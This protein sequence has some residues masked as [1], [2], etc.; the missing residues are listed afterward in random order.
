MRH[1]KPHSESSSKSPITSPSNGRA[2]YLSLHFSLTFAPN[3]DEFVVGCV[4]W[5][6]IVSPVTRHK[7]IPEGSTAASM[8][9]TVTVATMTIFTTIE[10]FIWLKAFAPF[11][12][13]SSL[14]QSKIP[15]LVAI[16]SLINLPMFGPTAKRL[17]MYGYGYGYG[18]TVIFKL[19]CFGMILR[20]NQCAL[21]PS[22]INKTL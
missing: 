2:I 4:G 22:T 11:S 13:F 9:P 20:Q 5:I 12:C 16:Q 3:L 7:L 8:P 21:I 19:R 14:S 10:L 1:V 18:Y 17:I 6:V 15:T